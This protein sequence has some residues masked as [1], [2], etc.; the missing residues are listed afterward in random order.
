MLQMEHLECRVKT[1]DQACFSAR[2]HVQ[3]NKFYEIETNFS[4]AQSHKFSKNLWLSIKIQSGR[5]EKNAGF[6]TS[7]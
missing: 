4:K 3:Q 5:I 7:K 1:L 6:F 2:M